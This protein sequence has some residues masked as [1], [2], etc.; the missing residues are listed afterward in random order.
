MNFAQ[1]R[2]HMCVFVEFGVDI[3][4]KKKKKRK[5]EDRKIGYI[6]FERDDILQI[7][8]DSENYT[9]ASFILFFVLIERRQENTWWK[10]FDEG[11][12]CVFVALILPL[13]L[14]ASW[15]EKKGENKSWKKEPCTN[16]IPQ[17]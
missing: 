7:M 10:I 4:K 11:I 6:H 16:L 5:K 12:C 9:K 13:F 8:W 2:F 3:R 15:R 1:V 17:S 14:C